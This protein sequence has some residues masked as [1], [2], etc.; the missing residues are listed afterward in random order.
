MEFLVQGLIRIDLEFFLLINRRL[1]S[2]L[3]DPLMK[4]LSYPPRV[5]WVPSLCIAGVM[6]L[7]L[8]GSRGRT[9]VILTSLAL[10][11]S[12]PI[13]YRILKPA[14]DRRRPSNPDYLVSGGRFIDGY[15][16]SRSYPSN[17]AANTSAAARILSILYPQAGLLALAA[18][19]AVGGSR[20]YLGQHYPL[21]VLG[22]LLLGLFLAE[23]LSLAHRRIRR[24]TGL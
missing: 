9:A 12:D 24:G 4:F 21:D 14:I 5:F 2:V 22:G 6:L 1:S 11:L 13:S 10:C 23:A 3:L 7:T 16:L 20:V 8:A 18:C 17:H 15:N 19:L